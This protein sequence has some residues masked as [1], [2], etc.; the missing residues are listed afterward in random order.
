MSP[1]MLKTLAALGSVYCLPI[2]R[3]LLAGDAIIGIV[4]IHM[5]RL[6]IIRQQ[7]TCW[8]HTL[9]TERRR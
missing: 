5:P 7:A 4:E 8:R 9:V 2:R 6:F 3:E 1:A